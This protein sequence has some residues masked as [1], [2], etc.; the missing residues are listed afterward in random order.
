M[1]NLPAG[2]ED[3][4]RSYI[5][6]NWTFIALTDDAGAEIFRVDVTADSRFAFSSDSTADPLTISGS[7]TGGDSDIS[8]PVTVSGSE[9][10]KS[11][12]D[13]TVRSDE[14]FANATLQ[15]S[16]D[17]IDIDHSISIE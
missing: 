13:A 4:I 11:A 9:L 17:T 7:V 3:D 15:T 12:S 16:Q 14:T 1:A 6:S 2:G 5:Q 8:L 10:Y